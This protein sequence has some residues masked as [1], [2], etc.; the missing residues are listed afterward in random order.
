VEPIEYAAYGEVILD[1][2]ELPFDDP[3]GWRLVDPSTLELLGAACEAYKA[4]D[5]PV[6]TAAFPCGAIWVP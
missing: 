1:G 3:D 5:N 4:A 2:E 6:L